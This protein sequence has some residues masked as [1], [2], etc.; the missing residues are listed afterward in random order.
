MSDLWIEKP[1]KNDN[2]LELA[3]RFESGSVK[4]RL[5][6]RVEA[7]RQKDLCTNADPFVLGFLQIA[8]HA[9]EP[10][11]VHGRVS[12]S[13]LRN[14]E[15]FQRAW[16]VWMPDKYQF[17][18][19][20][21]D[22]EREPDL[23]ERT[24]AIMCFS[25]GVDSCFTAF[26]HLKKKTTAFPQPLKTAVLVQGFDIPLD[27]TGY[28]ESAYKKVEYQLQSLGI[29]LYKVQT[30]FKELSVFWPHAFGSGVASVLALFQKSY[31]TGL[32][33]QGVPY[34]SY[35]NLVEG[36][37]PMTDPLLSSEYFAIIPD[38][39]G[40]QRAEKI[41][42]ISEWPEGMKY[43]RVCWEGEEKDKNCCDCE[44]CI[45]NILTFRALG[46]PRPEAFEQDVSDKRIFKLGPLKEI[47]ISVGYNLILSTAI[48]NGM[49]DA[50]W[51]ESLKKAISRSR[52]IRKLDST[53]LGR[54]K[55]RLIRCFSRVWRQPVS[56]IKF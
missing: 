52:K 31:R 5:W 22:D 4:H 25:G 14:L 49:G 50:T 36:S 30:N 42:V 13:L 48:A 21:A 46:L 55:L 16:A 27:Q 11:Q 37:N 47:T 41:K 39:G 1:K 34:S 7:S 18:E 24:D 15:D 8:M 6:Y 28:F 45:R 19:I 20:S 29:K 40:F 12:P 17:V 2:W 53:A 35:K 56:I 33:A 3:A 43:L 23:P 26:R 38:G 9:N 10:L 51:I 44:K 32:I 54:V